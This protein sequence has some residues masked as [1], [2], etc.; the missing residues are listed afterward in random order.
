MLMSKKQKIYIKNCENMTFKKLFQYLL[1]KFFGGF[2]LSGSVVHQ[3]S[4]LCHWPIIIYD[5]FFRLKQFDL[6]KSPYYDV[7]S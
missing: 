1:T 4:A 3:P 6:L 5:Q 2:E 7:G